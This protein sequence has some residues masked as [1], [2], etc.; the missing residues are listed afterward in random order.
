MCMS[1]STSMP[2]SMAM[3]CG[4]CET[5]WLPRYHPG[6]GNILSG[7]ARRHQGGLC[8]AGPAALSHVP[9]VPS[10]YVHAP[11]EGC[12]SQAQT[13][14]MSHVGP[15]ACSCPGSCIVGSEGGG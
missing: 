10:Y 2:M 12:A 13:C 6:G 5:S 4:W 8:Q 11:E 3:C 7:H 14:H 15:H 1:R 9:C